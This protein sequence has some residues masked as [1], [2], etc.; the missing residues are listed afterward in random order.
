MGPAILP[1]PSRIH[2]VLV[3]RPTTLE[4]SPWPGREAGDGRASGRGTAERFEP[5]PSKKGRLGRRLATRVRSF[6]RLLIV[7][8]GP[9]ARRSSSSPPHLWRVLSR[10]SPSLVRGEGEGTTG[11]P[12]GG[13]LQTSSP[14]VGAL[15]PNRTWSSVR[16]SPASS[17]NLP[18]EDALQLVPLY[19]E[20][21]SPKAEP[22]A[23]RWLA[24]Y[25][26]EGTP[27]LGDVARSRRVSRSTRSS[28]LGD[29][30]PG[31]ERRLRDRHERN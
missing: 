31:V 28:E 18:L 6:P 27:S 12:H 5:T 29:R 20:T 21:G 3:S 10:R 11:A 9:D 24:R 25:L 7:Y 4:G 13:H 26:S 2:R 8:R 16:L 22:A 30:H 23:R 19:F 15:T 17:P 14:P 1:S